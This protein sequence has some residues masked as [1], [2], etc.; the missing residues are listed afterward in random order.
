MHTAHPIVHLELHTSD[1]AQARS[2]YAELL[3]WRPQRVDTD[4]GSY[5]ALELGDR[6][7]GGIVECDVP[8]ALWLPYVEVDRIEHATARA[9]ELGATVLLAPREGPA[10]WRSVVSTP[11]G[12]EIAF[13][14]Q[15]V[16]LPP[17]QLAPG[18]QPPGGGTPWA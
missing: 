6:L 9:A 13:W 16:T 15:K 17:P 3:R 4:S 5:L 1:L 18:A 11:S 2:L 7:G 12:G 10:G 8:R 14:Q